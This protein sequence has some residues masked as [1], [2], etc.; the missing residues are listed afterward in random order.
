MNETFQIDE[1]DINILD[2]LKTMILPEAAEAN[3]V[4]QNQISCSKGQENLNP[5]TEQGDVVTSGKGEFT[6]FCL[7]EYFL[8]SICNLFSEYCLAACETCTH[9][10]SLVSSN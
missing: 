9:R 10:H 5:D 8:N 2:I 3:A 1:N 7:Q 4:L 6:S